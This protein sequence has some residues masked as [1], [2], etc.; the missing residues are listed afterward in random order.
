MSIDSFWSMTTSALAASNRSASFREAKLSFWGCQHQEPEGR[1]G[2]TS[3]AGALTLPP[4]LYPLGN[5]ALSP[6]CGFA[7]VAA[8]NPISMDDQWRKLQLVADTARKVWGAS[9]DACL[10]R[11][12]ASHW[13]VMASPDRHFTRRSSVPYPDC[14]WP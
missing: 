6:Q 13:S 9:P 7:S 3:S 11:R 12:C 2:R 10:T 4:D 8:G 5:L 14:N 1:I